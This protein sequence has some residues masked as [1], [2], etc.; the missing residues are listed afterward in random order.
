MRKVIRVNKNGWMLVQASTFWLIMK[1]AESGDVVANHVAHVGQE[2][3]VRKLWSKNFEKDSDF[4]LTA[5]F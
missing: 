1:P 4:P 5:G 3:Y 2:K